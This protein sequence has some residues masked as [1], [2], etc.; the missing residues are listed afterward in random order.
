FRVS[1]PKINCW[2]L[3]GR[4]PDQAIQP[5]KFMNYT[6][7]RLFIVPTRNFLQLPVIPDTGRLQK[8]PCENNI[9][10]DHHANP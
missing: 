4:T 9:R 5:G 2:A 6:R 3:F 8:I 7:P 10:R 1:E